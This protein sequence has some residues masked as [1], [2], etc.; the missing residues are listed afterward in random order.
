MEKDS[1]TFGSDPDKLAKLWTICVDVKKDRINLNENEVKSELLHDML[2]DKIPLDQAVARILPK[3]LA[4]L[5]KDIKLF[6]GNSIGFLLSDPDTE[7]SI[8]RKIKD[9]CKS[10]SKNVRSEAEH[11]VVAAIYYAAIA[12]ALINY[13][14]R[15]TSFS[16]KNL[17]SAFSSMIEVKWMTPDLTAIFQ[18]A[19][20]YCAEKVKH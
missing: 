11:D 4:Q 14:Q 12:S 2:A 17:Q 20:A 15:I 9:Y 3:V 5:C 13:N 7:L 10:L 16:Y 18:K 19:H 8:I 6:T 1:T